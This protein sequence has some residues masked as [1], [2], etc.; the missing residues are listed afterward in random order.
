MSTKNCFF[1]VHFCKNITRLN[2]GLL[3]SC[4]VFSVSCKT[5]YGGVV[6]NC[7]FRSDMLFPIALR[8]SAVKDKVNNMKLKMAGML[9]SH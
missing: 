2:V 4:Q 6:T 1:Y 7:C 3:R 5:V 8:Y 9:E